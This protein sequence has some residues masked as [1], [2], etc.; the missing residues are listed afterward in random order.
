M[1]CVNRQSS[2][3]AASATMSRL[4][5]P[6]STY[7]HVW[8]WYCDLTVRACLLSFPTFNCV[9]IPFSVS[10]H[11]FFYPCSLVTISISPSAMR[12]YLCSFVR[13][14]YSAYC[15][16]YSICSRLLCYGYRAFTTAMAAVGER[17]LHVCLQGILRQD[18][19]TGTASG[20]CGDRRS[21]FLFHSQNNSVVG[22][23]THG[24]AATPC[25]LPFFA[26]GCCCPI[27]G[28]QEKKE[29]KEKAYYPHNLRS[30]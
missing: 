26:F 23:K 9:A 7:Y 15:C 6:P 28:G 29:E 16:V 4:P 11:F 20:A 10:T 27:A 30:S 2:S 24:V 19:R 17:H 5:I 12:G 25:L 1:L 18:R 21:I 22:I 13:A 3:V 14:C 8:R